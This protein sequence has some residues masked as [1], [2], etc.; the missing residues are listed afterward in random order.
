MAEG[1]QC[2]QHLMPINVPNQEH[3]VN[4][5]VIEDIT[6]AGH[7]QPGDNYCNLLDAVLSILAGMRLSNCH[8]CPQAHHALL[9]V[10][11]Q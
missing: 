8:T 6:A 1:N 4:S 2:S 10:C 5:P 7:C 9:Q 3:H 11:P